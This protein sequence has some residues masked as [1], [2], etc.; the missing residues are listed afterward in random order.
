MGLLVFV[1]GGG[2]LWFGDFLRGGASFFFR[3]YYIFQPARMEEPKI[4]L[5]H[6]LQK[7]YDLHPP[8]RGCPGCDTKPGGDINIDTTPRSPL[9]CRGINC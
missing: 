4:R 3:D 7:R 5:L 8:K 6:P 1:G 9:T 2:C